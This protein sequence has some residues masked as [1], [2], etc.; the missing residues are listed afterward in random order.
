MA[1]LQKSDQKTKPITFP[2]I[3]FSRTTHH[4][5]QCAFRTKFQGIWLSWSRGGAGEE[6]Q[7]LAAG[8]QKKGVY[9]NY[10]VAII[11]HNQPK[12]YWAIL[13][14][15]TIG[16]V[17]VPIHPNVS[18]SE[19]VSFK[20]QLQIDFIFC[21]EIEQGQS[22]FD[23]LSIIAGIKGLVT[24]TAGTLSES[25]DVSQI[26]YQE[27]IDAG[28]V[29]IEQ[30]PNWLMDELS[31]RK[32]TDW[33]LIT[34]TSGTIN[35][36]R[37]VILSHAMILQA[38]KLITDKADFD[39]KDEV[40]AFLPINSIEDQ[41]QFFV[42]VVVGCAFNT[43]ESTATVFSDI[44]QIAPSFILTT[45]NVLSKIWGR[46]EERISRASK[47]VRSALKAALSISNRVRTDHDLKFGDRLV[48]IFANTFF[49]RPILQ[50][51]GFSKAHIV[52]STGSELPAYLREC[53]TS[54]GVDIIELYGVVEAG[55]AVAITDSENYSENTMAQYK[56]ESKAIRIG[57][58]GGVEISLLQGGANYLDVSGEP[59][60]ITNDSGWFSPGDQANLY[61]NSFGLI[62]RTASQH[63][64]S[65]GL[66]FQPEIYE[67]LLN[68]SPY[69]RAAFVFG[70]DG[71]KLKTIFYPAFDRLK[72]WARLMEI[73]YA[74]D[75]ELCA[76]KKVQTLF[77]ELV[78]LANVE[79]K[80]SKISA[81]IVEYGICTHSP[82]LEKSEIT[83]NGKVLRMGSWQDDA[84]LINSDTKIWCTADSSKISPVIG[85][86]PCI[87]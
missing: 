8:L 75:D 37:A 38:V 17:P 81:V 49:T 44:R 67:R 32:E 14:A 64:F 82:R 24:L 46:H 35:P 72:T 5:D 19:L 87:N 21:D 86:V 47:W 69:V 76:N 45:P 20:D 84:E 53:F 26:S 66:M 13:A 18:A 62:G 43:P 56:I 10:R 51:L 36:S 80:E 33:A 16:A 70:D 15:Q 61:D 31:K 57:E 85:N 3:F 63:Q 68:N 40:F 7:R 22:L 52:I 50:Q 55:G 65:D 77:D 34:F 11:G 23:A 79:I 4:V 42:S 54:I 73:S 39:D 83:K 59:V 28:K 74:G 58:D 2:E 9:E 6:I 71:S 30:K 25:I 48:Y 12:L 78:S 41:L 60:P 1:G 29:V 27:V